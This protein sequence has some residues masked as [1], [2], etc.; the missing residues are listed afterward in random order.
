MTG[1][2]E[3]GDGV[4]RGVVAVGAS[5]GGVEA[6]TSFAAG[7]PE[8]LPY[9]VLVVLHMPPNAP[10]VLP[11]ILDRA[12]RLPAVAA[13]DSA[14]LEA[15]R[16]YVGVPNRHLMV[17]DHRIMLSEGP[18]EN[19]NRPAVNT[20]FRSVAV[21][22]G[23]RAIGV[24]MSGVLDDGALGSGAIRSRGGVT[25]AQSP[26]DA[27]FT[28]MPQNA[29]RAGVIQH[30]A[31]AADIGALLTKLADRDIEERE[32]EPDARLELE[33]RIAMGRKFSAHFDSDALGPPSGYTCPDCNGSLATVEEGGFRCQVGHAW[34][35]E[36]LLE[37][38]DHEVENALW[39]AVRSLQEKAKLSRRLAE[40]AGSGMLSRRYLDA[41]EEAEQAMEVLAKRLSE[42]PAG[43]GDDGDG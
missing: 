30:Q 31:A 1:A 26:S 23:P 7:L 13:V 29:L 39:V 41:A 22:F 24:V 10:S 37:A 21:T 15:G 4:L 36:A 11:R 6:L 27:L 3:N 32:M 19:M 9:A 2:V 34:T 28:A 35:A 14:E 16:I 17:R 40:N 5:A 25:V 12:G 38:R 43:T 33:N 18:T 42:A 8:D 20:L